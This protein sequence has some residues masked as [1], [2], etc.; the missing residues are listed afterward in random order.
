MNQ[1]VHTQLCIIDEYYS[2]DY[3][4]ANDHLPL[5]HSKQSLLS[6]PFNLSLAFWLALA[7][8]M[9]V[10]VTERGLKCSVWL[11][12][13]PWELLTSAMRRMCLGSFC[14]LSLAPEWD[15][16]NSHTT[17]PKDWSRAISAENQWENKGLLCALRLCGWLL[18]NNS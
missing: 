2:L 17:W 16:W 11:W 9:L 8:G 7:N 18:R 4:L 10:H 13:A 14:S 5:V 6:C 1:R 15:Q 12:L 3:Y